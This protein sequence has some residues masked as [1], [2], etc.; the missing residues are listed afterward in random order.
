MKIIIPRVA[1]FFLAAIF[2]FGCRGTPAVKTSSAEDFMASSKKSDKLNEALMMSAITQQTPL[3]ESYLIGP[4][5]LLDIE[6]YNID[7]LKKTVRVN[8]QGDIALPLVGILNIKGLTTAEAEQLIAKKLDKYV[9]ETVVTVFVREYKSQRISVIGA[10]KKPSVF[11]ITGQRYLLDMLM[12]AEG[13]DRDAGNIAYVI[14]P[15]LKTNPNGRAETIV[16]DLDE[17]IMK[18]NFSLNI[19]VFAGDIVN[20][21]K[22]GVFF[23][24]GSVRMP[25][26]FTLKGKTNLAQAISMA[27]GVSPI[28]DLTEVRIYRDNGKGDR[29][30][31]IVDYDEIM[32]GSK[33]DIQIAENDII[34]VPKSGIKDFFSGFLNTI[35]G[36]VSFG[37]LA[38]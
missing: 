20:V 10:V 14:R 23:V 1:F 17:L 16:I 29:D 19:P 3:E 6:A 26:V 21:P 34:I 22:G 8:S 30:I 24:D 33:P 37:T 31:I 7:E 38:M 5:D 15:T 27:Q 11:A 13:L 32:S 12:V 25:G 36:F 28:A 18:G 2:F 9:Q 4:E 35:R